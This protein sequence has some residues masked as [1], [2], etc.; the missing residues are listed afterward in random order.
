MCLN[1][2]SFINEKPFSNYISIFIFLPIFIFLKYF[3]R[4]LKTAK[5]ANMQNFTKRNSKTKSCMTLKLAWM[6][7]IHRATKPRSPIFDIYFQIRIMLQ[8]VLI[9]RLPVAM[10]IT[11]KIRLHGFVRNALISKVGTSHPILPPFKHVNSGCLYQWESRDSSATRI[12]F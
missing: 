1:S 3:C 9:G 5:C 8:S 10:A 2:Y 7:S 12:F 11:L 6:L 4:Y